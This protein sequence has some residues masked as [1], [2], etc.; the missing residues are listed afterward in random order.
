M[1]EF[2]F[3]ERKNEREKNPVC[4]IHLEIKQDSC[5]FVRN[6]I[7]LRRFVVLTLTKKKSTENKLFDRNNNVE[8]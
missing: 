5:G 1:V 6:P 3:K 4:T 7:K 8:V 2:F